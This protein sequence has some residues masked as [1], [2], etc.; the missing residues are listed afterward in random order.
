MHRRRGFT[1]I[2]LMVVISIIAVLMTILLPTLSGARRQARVT[3]GMANLRSC[4][5]VLIVY[6]N[7]SK[8]EFLNPFRDRL[9]SSEDHVFTDAVASSDA[10]LKWDFSASNAVW[11]TRTL[12]LLLVQLHG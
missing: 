7:D 12:R 10:S 1:L 6:T 2:E 4:A 8:E 9:A 5:Q 11:N 3:V